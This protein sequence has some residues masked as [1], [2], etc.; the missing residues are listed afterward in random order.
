MNEF[1][2]LIIFGI[3]IW[4]AFII[5]NYGRVKKFKE[6]IN[7][8]L[9][10]E[11]IAFLY[12]IFSLAI[13]NLILDQAPELTNIGKIVFF[14]FLLPAYFFSKDIAEFIYKLIHRNN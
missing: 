8:R 13:I 12:F 14:V 2:F 6:N 5:A 9:K 10:Y 3:I 4:T 7:C 1:L 11:A